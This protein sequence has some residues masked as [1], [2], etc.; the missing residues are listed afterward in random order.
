MKTVPSRLASRSLAVASSLLLLQ[1]EMSPAPIIVTL[2]AGGGAAM[3]I[4][5]VP[6]FPLAIAL[7]VAIPPLTPVTRPVCE[8]VATAS[9][10]VPHAKVLLLAGL[11]V[12]VN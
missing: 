5:D 4:V 1:S 6:V 2:P 11:L 12:A 10:D 7:I 3:V 8:T 9:F